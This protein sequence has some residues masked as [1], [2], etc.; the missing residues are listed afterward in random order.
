MRDLKSKELPYPLPEADIVDV[1]SLPLL[2]ILLCCCLPFAV[3]EN[4]DLRQ[5]LLDKEDESSSKDDDTAYARASI[6]SQLTFRWLNPLFERGRSEKLELH[7]IPLVPESETADK[8]SSLLEESLRKQKS[9]SYLLPKAVAR[10]IWKSLVVNAVFAGLN[11]VA[12]YI[13]PFL[14]TSFV[15][16]LTEKYDGSSYL[17]GLVLAFVFFFSK[18]AES[19][20][21]RLWYFGAHRIGVR[22]KVSFDRI[23]EFLGEEEQRS[24]IPTHSERTSNVAMEI[25]T[26]EYAWET[27][28]QEIKKPT[29]K[30]TH[31]LKI[32]EGNKIA[33]CGSV[34]SGTHLFKKCLKGLLSQKTV[35]YAT[36][37]L[38]FLDA[39]DIVLVMKDGLIV[40]SGKYE[41]LIADSDGELVRQMNA[42]RKSLDQ[43]NQP[44]EDIAGQFQTSQIEVVEEK[45]GEPNCHDKLSERSQEEETETGRVKWSVYSTFVTAAYKGALVPVVLLCQVLFQGLQMGSNYWI[46][47]A[48]DDNHIVSREKLIGIFVLLSGGSSIFIL[49]RA[50]LLATIAIETAQLLII[51]VSLPR[52][53]IDPRKIVEYNTPKTLLKD[54]SSSFSK[55]VAEF[56]RSS[57]SNH[58][59]NLV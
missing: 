51:L 15:N 39:A 8:A 22:T 52:S 27:G 5:P 28:D 19:L 56:S 36:H 40:Q 18:T 32:M 53:A 23:Q 38:E 12:S 2:L 14:I 17:Y 3:S 50:V 10:S 16:F 4:D 13:G 43:V 57:K 25:E 26:G 44:R 7:H 45:H 30:I 21:Q 41:E 42:H 34:G 47:W 46:A 58:R 31:K 35:I 9:E 59:K 48:T 24:V 11:T 33:V 6:W 29:I 20:T 37:Q 49:G 55:L 1:A 54:N